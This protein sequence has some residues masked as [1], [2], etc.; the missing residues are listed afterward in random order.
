[1]EEFTI[2]VTIADRIYRLTIKRSEEEIVRKAARQIEEKMKNYAENYAYNDKQDLLAMAAL[3]FSTES[4]D[5]D[6]AHAAESKDSV[7]RLTEIDRLLEEAIDTQ[8]VL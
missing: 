8:K 4:L 6:S 5:K 3:H 1:M 2:T 7:N